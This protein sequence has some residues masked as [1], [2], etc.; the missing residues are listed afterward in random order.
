MNYYSHAEAATVV[1]V[2]VERPAALSIL[3]QLLIKKMMRLCC[4]SSEADIGRRSCLGWSCQAM[5]SPTAH[6]L[7]V[8]Y[9]NDKVI[10]TVV[11][12]F[13]ALIGYCRV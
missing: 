13:N 6:I 11:I 9:C 10:Y 2:V 7:N 3:I 1:T 12:V 5:I 4:S 8:S